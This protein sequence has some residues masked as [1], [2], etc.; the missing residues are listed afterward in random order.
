M[1]F[2]TLLDRHERGDLKQ[3]EAAEMLEISERTFRRW[4]ERLCDEGGA[5]LVDRR[6]LHPL[7]EMILQVPPSRLRLHF[8]RAKG[9]L[10]EDPYGAI[11]LFWGPHR[12]TDFPTTHAVGSELA[13]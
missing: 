3:M 7:P 2:E 11:A 13:A 4:R 12:I 5:G 6:P 9:R 10:N 8:V 1:R